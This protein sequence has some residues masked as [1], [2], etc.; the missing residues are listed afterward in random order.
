MRLVKTERTLDIPE[1]VTVKMS[2]RKITVSG[3]RGELKRDFNHVAKIDLHHDKENNKIVNFCIEVMNPETVRQ[4]QYEERTLMKRRY[5][6]AKEKIDKLMLKNSKK[7]NSTTLFAWR[8]HNT[9]PYI[10]NIQT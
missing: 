8:V 4:Y 3:P 9:Q 10:E 2:G 7:R 6:A 5:E 1:G